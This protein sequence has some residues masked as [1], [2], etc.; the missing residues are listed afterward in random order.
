MRW[1]TGVRKAEL[2]QD[3]L[4]PNQKIEII[5]KIV[6]EEY[7]QTWPHISTKG[8]KGKNSFAMANKSKVFAKQV[9]IYFTR[10]FTKDYAPRTTLTSIAK[11]LQG[12]SRVHP[13]H[14]TILHAIKMIADAQE[15]DKELRTKIQYIREAIE[16]S[17]QEERKQIPVHI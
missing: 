2:K 5:K 13:A 3:T 8:Q 15:F 17:L 7:G 12:E 16:K 1:I 6:C 10:E 9:F 14:N 11:L 4:T